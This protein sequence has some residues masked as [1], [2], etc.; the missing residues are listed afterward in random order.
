MGTMQSH[1]SSRSFDINKII[2]CRN[3]L[4]MGWLPST[5]RFT[6]KVKI[7]YRVP[8]KLKDKMAI[9]QCNA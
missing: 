5:L 3:E 9:N 2:G 7:G 1:I 6:F 4:Q 8:F